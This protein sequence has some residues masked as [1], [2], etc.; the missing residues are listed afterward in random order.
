MTDWKSLDG[1]AEQAFKFES[2]FVVFT[3]IACLVLHF[4]GKGEK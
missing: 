4:M 3:C 2:L 1:F